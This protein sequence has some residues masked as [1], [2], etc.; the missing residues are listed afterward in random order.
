[1]VVHSQRMSQYDYRMPSTITLAPYREIWSAGDR[2]ANFKSEVA[3]Y[4][5]AD[6]L[7][8]LEN[9][10]RGT[11]IPVGCLARYI[12]VKWTASNSEALMTM[13]PIVLTQM[14]QKV[15]EA[16]AEG[17][18]EARLRAY[19]ALRQIVTWLGVGAVG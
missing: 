16:E 5:T 13:G 1:M 3:C 19:E 2:D 11:G 9:L 17:T 12:L 7:P 8:T 18:D 10:S 6:P 15:D 14:R 4:T